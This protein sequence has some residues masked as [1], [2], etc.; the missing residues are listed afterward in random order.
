[1]RILVTGGAGFIGSRLCKRLYDE[2]HEVFCLDNLQTGRLKNINFF[3]RCF[4]NI[5]TIYSGKIVFT[6]L[7]MM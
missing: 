3:Y 5:K 1:M 4:N 7:N 2:G 6:L